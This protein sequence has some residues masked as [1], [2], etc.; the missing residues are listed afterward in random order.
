MKFRI[1]RYNPETDDAPH[2]KDYDVE[3][4]PADRMLL[5]ALVRIKTIDDTL[6][7]RRSCREGVCGSDAMNVNGKNRLAC[8][9]K[10]VE[11]KEPVVIK[12]LPGLPIIRD[13]IVDMTQFFAQ[14]H[15]IK[16]YVVDDR[17]MPERER[18]QTPEQREE[19]DGLYECILCACCSTACPSFW[20]NPDKYVGP[21][22]LL[23]A[24][25][26]IV[27]SR[28]QAT[29]ERLD[30]LEDPYRLFRC[31]TIMNCTDV[32]PKGLNPA[33][34]ISSIKELLVRRAV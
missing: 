5:D 7:L 25:R 23:Q 20:W 14:Y 28:D 10:L 3:I 1:Q 22:G 9:T 33:L 12:P 2:F 34:A 8:I 29:N 4:G 19:L 32:C 30:G 27:D 21:A 6:S 26:F 31:H 18:L 13:L 15:S 16:P 24:Y 11:L 17:P